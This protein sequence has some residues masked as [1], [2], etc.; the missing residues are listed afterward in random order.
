[1]YT[2]G[3]PEVNDNTKIIEVHLMIGITMSFLAVECKRLC[4]DKT[5]FNILIG[6]NKFGIV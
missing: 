5:R 4:E 6:C 3:I 1:M 2:V